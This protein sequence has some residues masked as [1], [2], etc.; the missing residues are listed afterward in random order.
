M[1]RRT[2]HRQPQSRPA[3]PSDKSRLEWVS[4]EEIGDD[5]KKRIPIMAIRSTMRTVFDPDTHTDLSLHISRGND[6][7]HGHVIGQYKVYLLESVDARG[8]RLKARAT[9][10]L[11]EWRIHEEEWFQAYRKS[12]V[13][14]SDPGVSAFLSDEYELKVR[15]ISFTKKD[16]SI[17]GKPNSNRRV[18]EAGL[19]MEETIRSLL[20]RKKRSMLY[21]VLGA[22]TALGIS[23][24]SAIIIKYILPGLRLS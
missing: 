21:S 11:E 20:R 10:I 1:K 6:S 4:V 17:A 12:K 3:A 24:L 23:I 15:D 19:V 9:V 7:G 2:K 13:R 14:F 16:T 8:W 5:G 18:L 22:C